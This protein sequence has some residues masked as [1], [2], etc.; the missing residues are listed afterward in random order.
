ME[1]RK[2]SAASTEILASLY[3]VGDANMKELCIRLDKR[4][5][6]VTVQGLREKGFIYWDQEEKRFKITKSGVSALAVAEGYALP[7]S[8]FPPGPIT[9]PPV[10]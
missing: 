1:Q 4:I 5:Q 10:A 6:S 9:S 3:R 8:S 7:G 2:L